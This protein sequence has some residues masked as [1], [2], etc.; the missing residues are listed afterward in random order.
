M[1][2]NGFPSAS[3]MYPAASRPR[4]GEAPESR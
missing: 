4:I 1:K 3:Q 2:K